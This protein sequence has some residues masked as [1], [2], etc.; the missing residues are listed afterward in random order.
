MK[1]QPG[2]PVT[3]ADDSSSP[4]AKDVVGEACCEQRT[5]MNS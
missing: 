5:I 4:R 2:S 3:A 1:T